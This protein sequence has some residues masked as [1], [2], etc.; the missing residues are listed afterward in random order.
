M[1][2]APRHLGVVGPRSGSGPGLAWVL[3]A[4]WP[5]LVRGLRGRAAWRASTFQREVVG[6]SRGRCGLRP[7]LAPWPAPPAGRTDALHPPG[8]S[9]VTPP[10]AAPTL[11]TGPS[12]VKERRP[13]ACAGT[14]S[15]RSQL[16]GPR[17]P[18]HLHGRSGS[19]RAGRTGLDAALGAQGVWGVRAAR[20][21]LGTRHSYAA[22]GWC[23]FACHRAR[24]KGSP[25]WSTASSSGTSFR[26]TAQTALVPGIP[27]ARMAS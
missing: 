10:P 15:P 21:T 4:A 17:G 3:G 20:S 5:G 9:E 7:R 6:A 24:S 1:V 22:T 23:R 25:D 18:S 19:E 26:A 16:V 2:A 11:H 12:V 8:P 14:S 27:R 13:D